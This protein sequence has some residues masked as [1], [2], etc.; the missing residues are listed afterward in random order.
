M[1][2]N[3]ATDL[4]NPMDV[5]DE[6]WI[7]AKAPNQEYQS[8]LVGKWMLFP[9]TDQVNEAWAKI[10]QATLDSKLGIAAKV[11]TAKPNSNAVKP[12]EKL[13]CIY[14][15]SYE[16][17]ADLLRVLQELRN[18]GFTDFIPY[19][20]DNTTRANEYAFN[21]PGPVSMYY[22]R[23]GMIELRVPKGK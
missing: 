2:K 4:R 22:A 21:S 19:K 12:N 13:I 23:P 1:A 16:D 6:Y 20:T 7:H 5:T 18:M 15:Y 10:R 3:D 8:A 11:A 14:T 17:R 9:T